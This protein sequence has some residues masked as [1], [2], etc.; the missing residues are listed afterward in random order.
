M[1]DFLFVVIFSCTLV[2]S[3]A[4]AQHEDPDQPQT[5][6]QLSADLLELLRSEMREIANGMQTI[7]VS[8][9]IAD[10]HAVHETGNKIQS[11]YILAQ[12]L[13]EAQITELKHALPEGFKRLDGE[14]HQ[15][16]GKLAAAAKNHD[17][18]S[19]AFQYYRMLENCTDCHS[20]YAG[21]RFPGFSP[22]PPKH[23]H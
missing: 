16:A 11:S 1:S 7:S 23:N 6:V 13:T 10:W 12:S 18:E 14:F 20:A 9:A 19:V 8:L 15:R 4:F 22:E 17:A 2:A 21:E 5:K 3:P